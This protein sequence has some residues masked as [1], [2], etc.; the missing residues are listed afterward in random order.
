MHYTRLSTY[1]IVDGTFPELTSIVENALNTPGPNVVRQP[2]PSKADPKV[3]EVYLGRSRDKR[4][5]AE[6]R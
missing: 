3:Q 2:D 5:T 6:V 4:S 1:D